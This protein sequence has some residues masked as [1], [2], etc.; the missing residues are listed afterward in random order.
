M[1]LEQLQQHVLFVSIQGGQDEPGK[2]SP[3][4][5]DIEERLPLIAMGASDR[6]MPSCPRPSGTVSQFPSAANT[7]PRVHRF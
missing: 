3:L 7:F 1:S 2:Q 6:P 4:L 5:V